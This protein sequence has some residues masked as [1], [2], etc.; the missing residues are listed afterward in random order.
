L[1]LPM[2]CQVIASLVLTTL[3]LKAD[4]IPP[5]DLIS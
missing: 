2:L 1:L 4:M 3:P 5:K